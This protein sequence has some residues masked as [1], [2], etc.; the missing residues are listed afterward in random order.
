MVFC[1]PSE[2][3]SRAVEEVT[4]QYDDGYTV[5]CYFRQAEWHIWEMSNSKY[6]RRVLSARRIQIVSTT[7]SLGEFEFMPL[8]LLFLLCRLDIL[9]D[10]V[11]ARPH[12]TKQ[13]LKCI[14]M[15]QV[16]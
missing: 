3:T 2:R 9:R 7:R 11:S 14:A 15:L 8:S 12:E 10:S 4:M 1:I 6:V 16:K 5:K 13:K